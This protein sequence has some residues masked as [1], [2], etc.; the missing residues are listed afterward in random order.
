MYRHILRAMAAFALV[1]SFWSVLRVGG[2]AIFDWSAWLVVGA[3]LPY[4]VQ[5]RALSFS[6]FELPAAGIWLLAVG[7]VLSFFSA[8]DVLE[9]LLKV[10]ALLLAFCM[11]LAFVYVLA[12]KKIFNF[13]EALSLIVASGAISSAVVILQGRFG[14]LTS[15][16]PDTPY[17]VQ[18]WSRLTIEAGTTSA[19][20]VVIALGLAIRS[21]RWLL[22]LLPVLL[23]VY[24]LKYSAS[25]TA[26]LAL[27]VGICAVCL[28]SRAYSVLLVCIVGG[29]A[30]MSIALA[31][32]AA[33]TLLQ[34]RLQHLVSD[35]GNYESVRSRQTQLEHTFALI[36]AKTIFAG[37]G[38]SVGDLP[39]GRDVHDSLLAALFHFGILGLAS[40]CCL[41]WF[42]VG[43]IRADMPREVK[44]I[45]VGC[46]I[47]FGAAYL[48]G[49]TLS[50]R[51][52]W[53][54]MFVMGA[55]LLKYPATRR[56]KVRSWADVGQ[57]PIPVPH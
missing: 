20:T 52:V 57:S 9:H 15:L 54:P 29:S 50:R 19:L 25:L 1:V 45:L 53:I 14:I 30:V 28:Y 12:S 37:N 22:Y 33:G 38:Y 16:V 40:Q 2:L 31:T 21:R 26:N 3:A 11:M 48:T 23:G 32:G 44:G 6:K 55:Y 39:E 34:N 7:G 51:S 56:A 43:K 49:P 10:F 5:D 35:Q 36:N 8:S 4:R 13:A 17:G 46:V 27:V 42:F 18:A 47:V 24:S 41:V